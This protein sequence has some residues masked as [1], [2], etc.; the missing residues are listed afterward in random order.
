MKAVGNMKVRM[1]S[2]VAICIWLGLYACAHH[3]AARDVDQKP[4]GSSLNIWLDDTLIPYLVEQFGR[5][6]RFKE[7]PVL[8]VRMQ[9]DNVQPRIDDLT[10]QIR[11][12]IMDALLNQPGL[13]LSWRPAMQPWR[14]HR[15]LEDVSCGDFRKT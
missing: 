4:G 7:Q 11:Q 12:K 13:D 2:V 15:S 9:G 6:P 8:L 3:Q 1:L 10:D 5:H 14:H